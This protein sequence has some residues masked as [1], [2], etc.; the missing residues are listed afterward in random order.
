MKLTARLS[1]LAVRKNVEFSRTFY[2]AF[3]IGF[4]GL[5]EIKKCQYPA[6]PND[7]QIDSE[8]SPGAVFSIILFALDALAMDIIVTDFP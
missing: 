1:A 8:G 6:K 5:R 2:F 4:K 3:Q 7:N